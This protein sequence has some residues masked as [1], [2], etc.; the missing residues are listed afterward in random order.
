MRPEPDWCAPEACSLPLADQPARMAEWDTL[1][2]EAVR[3]V[4][5][6]GGGV[7]FV[8]DRGVAIPAAVA[9]L[10]DRE[11]QCCSFLEFTLVVGDGTLSLGVTSDAGHAEVVDALGERAMQLLGST[12]R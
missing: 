4:S 1:F 3:E 6:T 12:G 7:R 8:V 5:P 2:I 11:S 10:A 9:D